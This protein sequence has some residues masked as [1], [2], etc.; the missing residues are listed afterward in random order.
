MS[1]RNV[2]DETSNVTSF[3]VQCDNTKLAHEIIKFARERNATCVVY[4]AQRDV[5][6][7]KLLYDKNAMLKRIAV[8]QMNAH[9][10]DDNANVVTMQNEL[11]EFMRANDMT[12]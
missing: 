12:L 2:I 3:V 1:T 10:D 9:N 7:A 8:A 4:R 11:R 6:R 5:E